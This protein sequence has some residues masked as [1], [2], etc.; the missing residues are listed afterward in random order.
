MRLN[1]GNGTTSG[2][3]GGKVLSVVGLAILIGTVV[4][5]AAEDAMD[6]KVALL[7]QR[8]RSATRYMQE[9]DYSALYDLYA[10]KYRKGEKDKKESIR[11]FR[12]MAKRIQYLDSRI[13]RI[14]IDGDLAKVETQTHTKVKEGFFRWE[15]AWEVEVEYWIFENDNWFIIPRGP[16]AREWDETRAVEVPVPTPPPRANIRTKD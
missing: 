12:K 9:R 2:T 16:G 14:W 13:T 15:P 6:E 3:S 11:S 10:S 8:V 7:A 5:V 1:A 4:N